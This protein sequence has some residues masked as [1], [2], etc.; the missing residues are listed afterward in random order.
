MSRR[1]RPVPAVVR[2][3]V[4]RLPLDVE[5]ALLVDAARAA[6]ATTAEVER[7]LARN[8][9]RVRGVDRHGEITVRVVDGPS[10]RG[11]S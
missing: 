7:A 1:R 11:P 4:E 10:D 2:Q 8:I 3:R 5:V 6:G 9:A